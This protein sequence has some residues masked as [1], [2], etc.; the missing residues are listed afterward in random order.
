MTETAPGGD[1]QAKV[2]D[3]KP[4]EPANELEE[5]L[6]QLGSGQ[7]DTSGFLRLLLQAK[8]YILLDR[9]P[10]GQTL[11]GCIPMVISTEQDG[12]Q[13]LAVF[14]DPQRGG[15][16]SEHFGDYKWVAQVDFAWIVEHTGDSCGVILNPGSPLGIEIA[17]AG[18]KE[19]REAQGQK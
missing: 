9:E 18:L 10:Q 13:L 16:M 3:A 17:A 8:L 5:A 14:S 4:F 2:A 19:I 6:M 15:V 7:I 11:G 12:P 1:N